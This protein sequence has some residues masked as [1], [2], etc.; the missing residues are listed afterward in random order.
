MKN[1][2]PKGMSSV[3]TA[4]KAPVFP[5]GMKSVPSV[6]KTP[7]ATAVKKGP[8]QFAVKGPAQFAVKKGK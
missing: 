1:S 8:A 7:F 4:H 2:F 3:P 6:Q 5:K